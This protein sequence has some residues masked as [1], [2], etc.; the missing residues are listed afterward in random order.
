MSVINF[1]ER[2]A[3]VTGASTGLG[4]AMVRKLA[5]EG[6]KTVLAARNKESLERIAAD[7]TK[8]G[9]TA[10]VVPTDVRKEADILHLFKTTMD[11]FGRLDV[12]VNNAGIAQAI[13]TWDLTLSDWQAIIETNLTSAFICSREAMKIMKQQKRGRI[14]NIGSVSS[15][16]PRRKTRSATLPPSVRS[17][18]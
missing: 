17:T 8:A 4:E 10:L 18:G 6:I 13:P 12:L 11:T 1:R 5:A 14:I 3:I 2:V 15:I 7:I 9:G 16:V